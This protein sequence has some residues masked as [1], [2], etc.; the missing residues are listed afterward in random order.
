MSTGKQVTFKS[1]EPRAGR[2]VPTTHNGYAAMLARQ[3]GEKMEPSKPFPAQIINK[4]SPIIMGELVYLAKH[5]DPN[6]PPVWVILSDRENIIKVGGQLTKAASL[7]P[8]DLLDPTSSTMSVQLPDGQRGAVPLDNL[9]FTPMNVSTTVAAL[10]GGQSPST[11]V[12]VARVRSGVDDL[13]DLAEGTKTEV[14]MPVIV[15]LTGDSRAP[16][17]AD[18]LQEQTGGW[19][20]KGAPIATLLLVFGNQPSPV[21]SRITRWGG[22]LPF[23]LAQTMAE[24]SGIPRSKYPSWTVHPLMLLLRGEDGEVCPQ[25]LSEALG[26]I[27]TISNDPEF[28][29]TFY[30]HS[31]GVQA[32][33]YRVKSS[34]PAGGRWVELL[35]LFEDRVGSWWRH[36]EKG[37][38]L[39]YR[40][41]KTVGEAMYHLKLC[42]DFV[43]N[44]KDSEG[45][46]FLNDFN[47]RF[48]PHYEGCNQW[49]Y[50]AYYDHAL[51]AE[52]ATEA[53]KTLYEL[54]NEKDGQGNY[55][56]PPNQCF[57]LFQR[58][59]GLTAEVRDG[60]KR[61]LQWYGY[62]G[63]KFVQ[64]V[65]GT[66][67]YLA[68]PH[69]AL[70]GGKRA[71]DHEESKE[72][73]AYT[74]HPTLKGWEDHG[75]HLRKGKTNPTRLVMKENGGDL[76][77]VMDGQYKIKK[78]VWE[79]MTESQRSEY[80]KFKQQYGPKK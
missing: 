37:L 65:N 24:K 59:Y 21:V 67:R 18:A 3:R 13:L 17:F 54:I 15:R 12:S 39:E 4:D 40:N 77:H 50:G 79:E 26:W 43:A 32:P 2:A 34:D 10:G 75:G 23:L 38:T 71:R 9:R 49:L 35:Q 48:L 36:T 63:D 66:Q 27:L 68:R 74:R 16:E 45:T 52:I 60:C 22:S 47:S 31:T 20:R 61:G 14:K 51:N 53:N 42:L 69:V 28:N 57:R 41:S 56:L 72:K 80:L 70:M 7:K 55:R 11:T 30:K 29:Y 46:N 1:L 8:G 19:L 5:D 78:H 58:E 33:M 73:K 6:K 64:W 76:K 62:V 25:C 44:F